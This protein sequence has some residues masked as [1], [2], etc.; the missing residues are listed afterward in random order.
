MSYWDIETQQDSRFG[1]SWKKDRKQV[2]ASCNRVWDHLRAKLL[3]TAKVLEQ[4]N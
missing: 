2:I 1:G 3:H 4:F